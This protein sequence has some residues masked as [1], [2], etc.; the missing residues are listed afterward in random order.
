MS[1]ILRLR[2]ARAPQR[3]IN[4]RVF[5][6]GTDVA[7]PKALAAGAPYVSLID[8]L[9]KDLKDPHHGRQNINQRAQ[10]FVN[11][12]N[13]VGPHSA[14]SI[15]IREL[16]RWL[17][18]HQNRS[19]PADVAAELNR[20]A[21]VPDLATLV[22][23]A[24]WST[25]RNRTFDSLIASMIVKFA[26]DRLTD[27]TRLL[28]I[29]GLVEELARRPSKLLAANDIEDA[30]QRRNIVLPP[31]LIELIQRPT[32][33]ARRYGIADLFVVRDEWNRYE[34]GEIAHIEN[35]LPKESKR[36]AIS[37]LD[38]SEISTLD[39]SETLKTE[40]HDSQTTDRMQLQDH[41]QNE[42]DLAVHVAAQVEV[43]ASYGPVSIA[44]TA[45]ASFDYSQKDARDHAYTQAHEAISRAVFNVEERVKTVR[46][47]RSLQRTVQKD[48]HELKNAASTPVVGMYRWV[49]KIQRLQLFRYPHRLLL[50]FEIPEPAAFLAW[51]RKHTQGTFVTPDPVDLVRRD[52]DND[53]TPIVDDNKAT[54]PLRPSD[55]TEDNYEW[56]VAQYN[57]IGV[58][59]PPVRETQVAVVIQMTGAL[60]SA[61]GGGGAEVPAAN[62]V[63][64]RTIYDL[65]SPPAS[66]S[67]PGGVAIPK[68]YR[69]D[70]WRADGFTYSAL[71]DI[72]GPGGMNPVVNDPEIR[73]MLGARRVLLDNIGSS[74][75]VPTVP[76]V[77][78]FSVSGLMPQDQY[79][80]QSPVVGTQPLTAFVT[81]AHELRLHVIVTCAR[82]DE[83]LT[84]WKQQIYEQI[85]AAY[86]A[87]RR[88]HADELALQ[89]TGSGVQVKGDSPLRNKEVIFEELKRSTIELL[90]G[91]Q[92]DGRPAVDYSES[93]RPR[94]KLGTAAQIAP[95]IQF[96][97][98]AFEWENLTYVLYPYYWAGKDRW[99][100]IADVTLADPEFARFLRSGSARVVVPARPLFEGQVTMYVDFGLI[101][102]GGPVPAVDDPLYLSI[103]AEIQAQQ[104]PPNDGE[105]LESWEVRLP[106]S[107]LSLDQDPTLPKTNP[108]PTLDDPPANHQ[109]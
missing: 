76:P 14:L 1:E 48:K 51:R 62:S 92:F 53:M 78:A 7:Q 23:S 37:V 30:L 31:Q 91:Q 10:A 5:R 77:R 44:A 3:V 55:I 102:G 85:S 45:G 63:K 47:T 22:S 103:A 26:S 16:D 56:W 13:Y 54:S 6:L 46:A 90:V 4:D 33:L 106:T 27:L 59:A 61:D 67:E 74:T 38:Q 60:P 25:D 104:R 87:M 64:D 39:E 34:T 83:A 57:V 43:K 97:E 21:A 19:E 94:T 28:T 93:D 86:W 40:Q 42:T 17:V 69:V 71:T 32:R 58:E 105:A 80:A 15:P 84:A 9:I 95:E 36:R 98:Q 82:T 2:T 29:F 50:E 52:W 109:P 12:A 75:L 18:E 49:D 79:S 72:D 41:S 81:Y 68:G 24:A 66:G 107:L 89:E 70:R 100:E 65:I 8:Q 96:L 108:H 73:V 35:V 88:Q 101:W 99:T 11:S 20:L